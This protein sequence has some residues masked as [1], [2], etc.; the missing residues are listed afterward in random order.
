MDDIEFMRRAVAIAKQNKDSPIG[1]VIVRDD[2]VI[3]E[4]HNAVEP[5]CDPTAHAEITAIRRA[6][7][8]VGESRLKGATLYSTLQPCGMC[9]MA[10]I[11]AGISRV[12]YGAGRDQVHRMYFEDRHLDTM[13][14]IRDAYRDDLE[15]VGGV[16]IPGLR[17]IVLA[18]ARQSAERAADQLVTARPHRQ[19]M[20]SPSH[21][22]L[23]E[24]AMI[25][26]RLIVALDLEDVDA[27]RRLVDVLGDSVS[28][29]KIGMWLLF[30]PATHALV[31]DLVAGG[32]QVFLD[33]KMYDIAETIRHGV[34]SVARRGAR[35]VTIHGDPGIL[36]AAVAG[37]AGS[38]LGILAVSVL[39]SLDDAALRAMGYAMGASDLVRLRVRAA[40]SAGCAG[41]I[42]SAADHPDDLRAA[43]GNPDLL[44][45]TPGIR[46]PDDPPDDQRRTATP[47]EAMARGAD[48]IVVGR[49]ITR[50]TA[51]R[52]RA[53]LILDEMARGHAQR[54]AP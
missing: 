19:N 4:A 36:D 1:C 3:A 37:A 12:V 54:S 41:V 20:H 47:A 48:Y 14:F 28:F 53:K 29:Y 23:C 34:A 42:A 43:S 6:C 24:S 10:M 5:Q 39:T 11:W 15:M 16:V 49:P 22:A 32:R 33:Y 21:A 27:A 40:A 45:V 35:F 31:D 50:A 17:G 46:L 25:D 52:D 8:A 13:D 9:S 18:A 30:Q 7:Q 38:P 26:D 44:V 51:P 2:R